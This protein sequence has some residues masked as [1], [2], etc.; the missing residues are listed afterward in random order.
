MSL[1]TR[2]LTALRGRSRGEARRRMAALLIVAVA[3]AFSLFVWAVKPFQSWEWA[4]SDRLFRQ[5]DGSPN[6]VVV[7]IDD[8]TLQAFG[9]LSDWPRSLHSAAI[10]HLREAGASVVALDV[11]FPEESEGDEGLAASMSGWNVVLGVA[12]VGTINRTDGTT[13][14]GTV[15][16]PAPTLAT[17]SPYLGHVVFPEDGDGVVRRVPLAIR[18]AAGD[19]YPTLAVTALSLHFSRAPPENL[20]LARGSVTLAGRDVPLTDGNAMRINFVGGADRFQFL[21]YRDVINGTFDP[22][23]VRGKIVLIGETATGTGDRHLTPIASTPLPGVY[24]HANALDTL[25]RGR[26]LRETSA[27]TTLLSMLL[28]GAISALALPR[29]NLRWGL[30]ATLGLGIAY[31]L[32][33]WSLFDRGWVLP[34][35]NPLI[36]VALL[37]VVSLAHRITSESVSRREVRELFGRYISPQVAAELIERADR[38][39]LRLGGELRMITI[40]FA[41]LRGFTS[42]SERRPATQV[43][44]YINRCFG[45]IIGHVVAQGGMVN[46]FGGDA[47]MAIWN[48]PQDCPDHTVAAC[49]AAI[50][51]AKE[52]ERLEETD[53]V[54]AAS[55]FGFGINTGEALVGNVG[56]MGRLEYTAIGDCVN[57]AARICGAAPAGEVWVGP[58]TRDVIEGHLPS[59][60]LGQFPLKG[61]DQPVALFRIWRP[62][63]R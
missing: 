51:S 14:V 1:V 33:V 26:F 24:L 54:L 9:R 42:L 56:S 35:L 19:E 40:L 17:A 4:L 11:L 62:E 48:A 46:K 63:D 39:E 50:A 3:L 10:D 61:K 23:V 28:L 25:L 7:G 41:D 5:Q 2:S 8:E 47:I 38:G 30:A 57:L 18:D 55:G 13:T 22:A 52:L 44:E 37:Y 6:I 21:S 53:P 31:A 32:S 49:H 29:L 12:A 16:K 20:A 15:L 36:L 43:V 45:I 58:S 60:P 59:E 34:V 27:N